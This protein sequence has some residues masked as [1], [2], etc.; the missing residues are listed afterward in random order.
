MNFFNRIFSLLLV[1]FCTLPLIAKTNNIEIIGNEFVDDEVIFSLIKDQ[2]GKY[3]DD[4][5]KDIINTLYDTGNFE[6][7]EI[8]QQEDK[9]VIKII[10]NPVIRKINFFETCLS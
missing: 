5:I 3:S 9:I 1:F 7:I 2:E 10:E 6:S 4:D 8:E